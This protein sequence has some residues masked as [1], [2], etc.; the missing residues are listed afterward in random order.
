MFKR[1]LIFFITFIFFF[2]FFSCSSTTSPT[3][4]TK[5]SFKNVYFSEE[6]D[7]DGDGY[8]SYAKLNF[9]TTST[10]EGVQVFV[11][12]GVRP[13]TE[14]DTA[15]Y[16][17]YFKSDV[18]TTG[19]TD[20][21]YVEIGRPN[22][23][24]PSGKYD[25]VIQLFLKDKPDAVHAEASF[26]DFSLLK[27]VKFEKQEEDALPEMSISTTNMDFG[28]SSVTN[29]FTISNIGGG[30]LNWNISD[31]QAWLSVSST[32]G[33]TAAGQYNEITVTVDRSGLSAGSYTGTLTIVPSQGS[34]AT[35]AVSMT[36][37]SS[38]FT[39]TFTNP[40]YTDIDITV[41]GAGSKTA[42]VG[43]SAVYTFSSNPGTI[44]FSAQT[45]GKSSNGTQIGLK[46]SWSGSDDVSSLSD[47][48][49]NLIL[50]SDYFF[51]YLQNNGG[52]NLN[53]IYVNYDT[54]DQTVDDV[55]IPNDNKV[56]PMGYYKAFSSTEIVALFQGKSDGVKWSN[57][58]FP[59]TDNQAITLLNTLS[60]G[61]PGT[62]RFDAALKGRATLFPLAETQ[63]FDTKGNNERGEGVYG[64]PRY[65]R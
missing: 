29:S 35:I 43:G 3:K 47:K 63:I 38:A 1:V 21:K 42:A 58:N 46:M 9:E 53:P 45:S 12:V 64:Y 36:V 23:E 62:A 49:Y 61:S 25:L 32:Q 60:P 22:I 8:L 41:S 18:Y 39:L 54:Q 20:A 28:S 51:L 34:Q 15:S 48:T 31:D 30:V 56:Y 13:A 44:S 37:V 6:R 65:K 52:A 7:V 10:R 17:I 5:V 50:T 27:A 24:L 16:Y 33:S 40:L 4:K 59:G 19:K 55:V 11:V 26:T 57:I 14:Q 2:M